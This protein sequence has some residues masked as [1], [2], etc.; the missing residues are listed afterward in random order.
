MFRIFR[1]STFN[2]VFRIFKISTF[3][4]NLSR[5]GRKRKYYRKDGKTRN[6]V[7]ESRIFVKSCHLIVPLFGRSL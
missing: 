1:A 5:K 2:L 4:S 3:I 7:H 6:K